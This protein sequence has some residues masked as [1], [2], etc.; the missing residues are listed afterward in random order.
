MI[1]MKKM[2]EEQKELDTYLAKSERDIEDFLILSWNTLYFVVC[3]CCHS[4]RVFFWSPYG[5]WDPLFYMH[6]I[7]LFSEL[8]FWV[9]FVLL[10]NTVSVVPVLMD[11]DHQM[12]SSQ[13]TCVVSH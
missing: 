7:Y 2:Y 11:L 4:L 9:G 6:S 13:A 3:Y 8:F 5:M 10:F 1:E 12:L